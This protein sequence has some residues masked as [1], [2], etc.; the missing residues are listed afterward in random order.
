[1]GIWINGALAEEA[2]RITAAI[3]GMTANEA[4]VA[5]MVFGLGTGFIIAL[6]VVWFVLSVIADWRIFTK[7]GRVGWKSLIPIL[8][9]YEEFDLCWS[10][11]IGI[12]Y[13]IMVIAVQVIDGYTDENLPMV[14]GVVLLAAGIVSIVLNFKQSMKLAK[15]F[16][17]GTAFGAGLFLLGPVFRLVLGFGGAQYQ[18]KP[19]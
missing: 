4:A 17:K 16:G 10:G 7:A 3:E 2:T 9:D 1:M 5:G 14:L 18:G 8:N 12:F 6:G 15:A 13:S 19:E 11:S